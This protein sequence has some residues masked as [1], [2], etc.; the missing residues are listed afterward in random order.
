MKAATRSEFQ[1][2]QLFDQICD[3]GVIVNEKGHEYAA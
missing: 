2:K 1:G 3:L